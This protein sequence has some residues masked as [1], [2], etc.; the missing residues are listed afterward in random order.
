MYCWEYW[1]CKNKFNCP[2]RE[3]K[4]YNCWLFWE[5]LKDHREYFKKANYKIRD[6]ESCKYRN[7]RED[8]SIYPV[9]QTVTGFYDRICES[10]GTF[11][12]WHEIEHKTRDTVAKLLSG[13]KER[14][15]I[16]DVCCGNATFIK[17]VIENNN[18]E[19]FGLDF[20][21]DML[22]V[23]KKRIKESG[24][25]DVSLI[26]GAAQNLP[27]KKDSFDIIVFLNT[28]SDIPNKTELK[29]VLKEMVKV[30]SS[31]GKIYFSIFNKLN[32]QVFKYFKKVD[33]SRP[34][35]RHLKAYFSNT[36]DRII[37][38]EGLISRTKIPIFYNR[39][40]CNKKGIKGIFLKIMYN[41]YFWLCHLPIFSPILLYEIEK[42]KCD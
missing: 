27:F 28:S 6:C 17:K 34:S 8:G 5:N 12:G 11:R 10:Y 14:K 24:R 22:K 31:K 36:L 37:K 23:A 39:H 7:D 41:I 15:K 20:S 9:Y 35:L 40:A 33:L 13:E 42:G 32:P 3:Q 2:V 19:I 4:T 29:R 18:F 25:E 38:Q 21:Y 30:S 1:K 16:L 26:L